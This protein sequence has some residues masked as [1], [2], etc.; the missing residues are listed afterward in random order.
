MLTRTAMWNRATTLTKARVR[1][2]A[3]LI[4]AAS[5]AHA[6]AVHS[7]WKR[8]FRNVPEFWHASIMCSLCLKK[9]SWPAH[10]EQKYQ[11]EISYFVYCRKQ[12]SFYILYL[13]CTMKESCLILWFWSINFKN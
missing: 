6:S 4:R 5:L 11:V 1:R 8:L 3:M 9:K 7:R 12:E 10:I 2:I 13:A